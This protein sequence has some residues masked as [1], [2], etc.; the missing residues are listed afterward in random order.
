MVGIDL[1]TPCFSHG[2]LYVALS[3]VKSFDRVRIRI[4][5]TAEQGEIPHLTGTYTK[6]IVYRDI[7]VSI[8]KKEN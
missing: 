4:R 3:R 7:L 1:T 8:S 6:N 2:Q 5:T